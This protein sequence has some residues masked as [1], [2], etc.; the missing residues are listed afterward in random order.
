ME[1]KAI[2]C[3]RRRESYDTDPAVLSVLVDIAD[4]MVCIA[5]RSVVFP[6]VMYRCELDHKEGL[7]LSNCAGKDFES[8]D[9][10]RGNHN[11]S[12]QKKRT[13]YSLKH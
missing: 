2:A 11:Q 13:E 1:G 10:L 7:M 12:I 5:S 4:G 6:V 3:S 9:G 8:P